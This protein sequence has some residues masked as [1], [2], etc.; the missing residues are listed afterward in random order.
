[1]LEKVFRF[2]RDKITGHWRKINIEELHDLY[3]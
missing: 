1:V 2:K 3:W